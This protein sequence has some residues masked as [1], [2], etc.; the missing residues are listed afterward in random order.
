M[1]KH[2]HLLF[3]WKGLI[4]LRSLVADHRS[5]ALF[6]REQPDRRILTAHLSSVARPETHEGRGRKLGA[7]RDLATL[8]GAGDQDVLRYFILVVALLLDPAARCSCCLLQR[9][10]GGISR[11]CK[12]PE[13]Y[14]SGLIRLGHAPARRTLYEMIYSGR[15]I[16]SVCLALTDPTG[17]RV[18]G[19]STARPDRFRAPVYFLSAMRKRSNRVD[20]LGAHLRPKSAIFVGAHQSPSCRC[21]EPRALHRGLPE[22]ESPAGAQHLKPVDEVF[23][24]RGPDGPKPTPWVSNK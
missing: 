4:A 1:S 10:G 6:R 14:A 20:R 16:V 7:V 3:K 18:S 23:T 2:G 9:R 13:P 17:T 11:C 15:R 8:L 12:L 24:R 5:A 19:S 22:R 21:D